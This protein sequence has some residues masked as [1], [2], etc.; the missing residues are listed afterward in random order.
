M[1]GFA[2]A[3][4]TVLGKYATFSG[5]ARRSEYW[6]WALAVALGYLALFV[7]TAVAR[8]LGLLV[9]LYYLAVLLPSVAVGVRRLHDTGKS[10]WLLLLGFVPL[11]GGIIL[12]VFTVLDSTPGSNR[13]GEN[14]KGVG[15]IGDPPPA[16]YGQPS[17][18]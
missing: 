11:I 15:G 8:P 18:F 13:Y 17:A 16:A 2:E 14:P 3:V 7:L 9:L 4:R 12:F 10:G 5:R 6:Y 1:V